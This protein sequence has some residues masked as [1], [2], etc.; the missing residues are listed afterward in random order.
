MF[1]IFKEVDPGKD[2]L[3]FLIHLMHPDGLGYRCGFLHPGLNRQADVLKHRKSGKDVCDLKRS[4]QTQMGDL[5][6]L[7]AKEV[8][9]LK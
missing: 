3:G 8:R 5:M 6:G 9:I 7:E 1:A 2:L 4:S